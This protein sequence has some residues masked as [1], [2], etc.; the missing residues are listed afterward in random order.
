VFAAGPNFKLAC[1]DSDERGGERFILDKTGNYHRPMI[2]PRGDRVVFT[3]VARW[4]I[5]SATWNGS[6]LQELA[7]GRAVAL[8]MDPAGRAE[9]VYAIPPG[10][11]DGKNSNRGPLVRFML[12]NPSR[13]E[14]VWDKTEIVPDNI[15]V[16]ADGK[17]IGGLFPWPMAGIAD[18]E[19]GSVT[20]IGRG[21][22]VSLSPGDSRLLWIFDGAHRNVS[23]YDVENGKNWTVS[24]NTADGMES[25]EAYHPRWSNHIRFMCLTGPYMSGIGENR[26]RAGG[27]GVEVF[28]GRFDARLGS[29]EKW[30]RVTSDHH[31]DFFPDIWID[32]AAEGLAP[33]SVKT[34]QQAGTASPATGGTDARIVVHARLVETTPTPSLDAIAPYTQALA[35]YVYEVVKVESGEYK[36]RKLLVAHWVI[37]GGKIRRNDKHKG[38]TYRLVVEPYAKHGELEGERLVMDVGDFRFPLFYEIGAK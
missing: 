14:T 19:N 36:D 27:K 31:P 17:H 5:F 24:V 28:A 8:W 18:I 9:W 10:N 11:V 35:A 26:I 2:T 30:V 15:Q 21:C 32:P 37:I 6:S 7:S 16:S 34:D 4:K 33:R 38:G 25:R 12:D 13:K 3:D 29:I 1:I 22:W 23:I 20:N